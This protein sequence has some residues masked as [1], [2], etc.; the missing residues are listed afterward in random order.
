MPSDSNLAAVEDSG[1]YGINN[2]SN[3]NRNCM[4]NNC[5][6]NNDVSYHYPEN[7][8]LHE[9][10]NIYNKNNT[11]TDSILYNICVTNCRSVYCLYFIKQ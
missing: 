4:T 3:N 5:I 10:N 6:A 2:N 11:C 8:S 9:D 1:L 7:H